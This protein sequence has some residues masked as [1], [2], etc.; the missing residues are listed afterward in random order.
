MDAMA[1]GHRPTLGQPSAF[2]QWVEQTDSG[3]LSPTQLAFAAARKGEPYW[4][5]NH[6][7][8][9]TKCYT[10]PAAVSLNRALQIV[11]SW[12]QQRLRM[13]ELN[14][15]IERALGWDLAFQA[16]H[17]MQRAQK[18]ARKHQRNASAATLIHVVISIL[19][20]D[21]PGFAHAILQRRDPRVRLVVY[22]KLASLNVSATT[23][24]AHGNEQHLS[25]I[26]I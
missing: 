1:K 13:A 7:C 17:K 25:L 19:E 22:N 12:E 23:I 6:F 26:H 9:E 11:Q 21:L 18:A 3:G 4:V 8:N 10:Y 24:D 16:T 5:K 14:T 15:S 2:L 20:N